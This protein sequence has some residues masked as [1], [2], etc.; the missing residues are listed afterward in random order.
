[1]IT[2]FLKRFYSVIF[3]LHPSTLLFK[4]HISKWR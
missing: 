2:Y 1:M 3:F 4:Y